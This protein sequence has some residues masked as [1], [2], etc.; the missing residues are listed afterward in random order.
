[1]IAR[2]GLAASNMR[3]L[4]AEAGY[5]NGALAYYF[6]SKEELLHAAYEYV[7]RQTMK[8]ITAATLNLRGIEALRAFCAEIV[9]DSALKL[10]EARVV[11]PFWSTALTDA[12]FAETF[13]RDMRSWRKQ[14]LAH[15]AEAVKGGE[16]PRP[17]DRGAHRA[18]VEEL[19]SMLSGMQVL[20][21]LTPTQHSP[22][23]MRALVEAA[24]QRLC[25]S[26]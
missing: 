12:S 26:P 4:A 14:M 5:A 3:A 25:A 23:M 24:L 9:P 1:L 16:I 21:V 10:L 15:L 2:D 7:S 17:V 6:D 18:A 13:E 22:R 19:V 11:V 8:R 20:A